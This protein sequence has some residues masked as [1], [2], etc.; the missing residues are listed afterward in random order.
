[1][2]ES[3]PADTTDETASALRQLADLVPSSRAAFGVRFD[4]VG[5]R[6][7]LVDDRGQVVDDDRALLVL[8][9]LVSAEARRGS[10]ALP[11]TA[12]R[13]AEQVAAFHGVQ[14]EWTGVGADA[15]ARLPATSDLLLAG[16]GAGRFV[17]PA[18]A[19][20]PDGLA[21]FARLVGLVA[22]TRLTLGE[23]DDRIPRSAVVR[24]DVRTPWAA[25]GAVMREVAGVARQRRGASTDLTEGIKVINDDGSWCLVVPDP[26]EALVRLWAEADTLEQS[27][28]L[29]AGW[30]DVVVRATR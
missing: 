21:A 1:L 29:L 12:T 6:L 15:V 26:S 11:V 18:V 19:S 14:I 2:D 20:T 24:A 30:S 7:R 27:H 9:D 25:K 13:V 8:V 17:I 4:R 28:R 10:V 5:E 3:R 23:I 22:R 16:D